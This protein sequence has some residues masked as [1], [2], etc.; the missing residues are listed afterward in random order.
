MRAIALLVFTLIFG[1]AS[2]A[3]SKDDNL[4]LDE[5]AN[6]TASRMS[7]TIGNSTTAKYY[8]AIFVAQ[9]LLLSL[10]S[11]GYE[12]REKDWE[13][14][15]ASLYSLKS[16]RLVSPDEKKLAK[17]WKK[18]FLM[19][20]SQNDQADILKFLRSETGGRFVEIISSHRAALEFDSENEY[21]ESINI[22][23][24][25]FDKEVDEILENCKC[26]KLA[27]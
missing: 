25:K 4:I 2:Y 8:G 24:M 3:Q 27:H 1:Q 17:S 10:R 26:K 13:K 16:L 6:A 20:F 9:D 18:S 22:A 14:L 21:S 11:Y 5:I 15:I 12:L 7:R 19:D 23:G